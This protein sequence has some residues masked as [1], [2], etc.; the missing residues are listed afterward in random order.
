MHLQAATIT[1]FLSWTALGA[2]CMQYKVT[3]H[4]AA[5]SIEK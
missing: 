5:R 3:A 1:A 2:S 4:D